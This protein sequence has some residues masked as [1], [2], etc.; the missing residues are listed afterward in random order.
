MHLSRYLKIY[1]SSL[2]PDHFLLFSTL[3]SSTALIPA[4][5]LKAAQDGTLTGPE[6]ETLMRLGMLVQDTDQEREQVRNLL[7]RAYRKSPGLKATVV[8][9]LDCNLNCS[10]CY[11][12]GFRHEQYMT[13]ETAELLIETVIR[14]YMA[15]GNNVSFT[16]YGGEALLSTDLIRK[17]SVALKDAAQAHGVQYIFGMVT[18]GT[19]L[20]REIAESLIPLGFQGAKFTLDGPRE[21][22]DTQRPFTSGAGSFDAIVNNMAALGG[23]IDIRLG[24]NFYPHN[25]RDY[26]RL[27]DELISR[28]I[29]PD[30]VSRVQFTPIMPQAGC[31]E[32]G[33]GCISSSEP[34]L[35]EALPYLRDETLARG[36]ATTTTTAS[37]CIVEFPNALVVN[38]D[39]SLYKC[40][41]FMGNENFRVGSL[42]EGISDYTASHCIGNWQ[43]DECLNCSYLPLCFGGC[44]FLTQ[45]QGKP[46]TELDCKRDF[47][48]ATLETMI[49]QNITHQRPKNAPA[50]GC[51]K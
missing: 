40:P 50:P 19:L 6:Q 30:K 17:I 46:L 3:R 51:K 25:Y 26:P 20:S 31:A 9:N 47:L 27:L 32:H 11:E 22:H 36:F 29:T 28:G 4:A 35:V 16:F 49:L 2:K 5:T 24:G 45:L 37:A 15:K 21:I 7:D 38:Y 1:P 39:G 43:T 42:A 12:E 33:S 41:A 10:Y 18:N 48:D 44:R 34:W 14:D 23:V 13:D 8:L